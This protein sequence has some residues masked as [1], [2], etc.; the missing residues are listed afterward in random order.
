MKHITMALLA[1][2]AAAASAQT[3]TGRDA[4]PYGISVRGGVVFPLE[5]SFSNAFNPTLLGLGA[6]YTLTNPIIKGGETFFA[7]DFFTSQIGRKNNVFP[8]TIN[9]RFY[10][11]RRDYGSRTYGFIGL[12][13]VFIDTPTNGNGFGG[14]FG[15]GIELGEH[16][17]TEASVFLASKTNGIG[18]NAAGVYLGY[19]F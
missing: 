16:V 19:R 1:G 15:G 2:V 18:A 9:Q 3:D 13:I 5:S 14:R 11:S 7:V 17:Y 4:T 6:E 8:V 10:T 12:G